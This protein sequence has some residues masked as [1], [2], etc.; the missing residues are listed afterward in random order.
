LEAKHDDKMDTILE[1]KMEVKPGEAKL[2]ARVE[3]IIERKT[4]C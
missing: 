4:Q 3:T 2:S 1:V